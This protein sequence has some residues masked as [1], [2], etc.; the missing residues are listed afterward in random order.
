MKTKI[1]LTAAFITISFFSF[2]QTKQDTVNIRNAT[3][4]YLEGYYTANPNRMKN[5]MHEKFVKRA[6]LKNSQGNY[7]LDE[8]TAEQLIQAAKMKPN[9]S[10][11]TGELDYKITFFDI[12]GNNASVKVISKQFIFFDYLHLLKTNGKWEIINVLWDVK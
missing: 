4:D 2:S 3:L 7:Y 8:I 9:E 1:L 12:H 11:K 10:K 5:A 6:F